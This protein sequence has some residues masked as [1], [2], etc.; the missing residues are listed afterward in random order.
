[1]QITSKEYG[2]EVEKSDIPV[3]I[4]FYADWCMPCRMMAPIFDK[5]STQYKGR[6]KF[7]KVDVDSDPSLAGK[8][9]VMGIPTL[10]LIDKGKERGRIVGFATE[11]VLKE[12]INEVI[13]H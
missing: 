12:K 1:M 2:K 10:V 5:L 11:N 13:I 8:F 6:V 4:D 3:V 7:V 9:E